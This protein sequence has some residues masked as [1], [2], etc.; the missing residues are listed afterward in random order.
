MR[1]TR[2]GPTLSDAALVAIVVWFSGCDSQVPIT[3]EPWAKADSA[4]QISPTVRT[5]T[6]GDL[7]YIS[8]DAPYVYV[9]T[10]PGLAY[11]GKLDILGGNSGLCDDAAGNVFVTIYSDTRS[12]NTPMGESADPDALRSQ[13]TSARMC[14]GSDDR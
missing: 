2:G 7:L 10:Y 3:Q 4:D 1:R 11:I 14:D 5:A 12:S 6:N 13:C 9:Y 8:S